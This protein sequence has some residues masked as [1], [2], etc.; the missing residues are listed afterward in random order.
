MNNNFR[1]PELMRKAGLSQKDLAEKA[2]LTPVGISKLLSENGNPSYD[3]LSKIA[4]ALDV[5]VSELF[6]PSSN[7]T[8][9][10]RDS[11]KLYSF[12]NKEDLRAYLGPEV[13]TED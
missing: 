1:I 10:V 12:D 2:G 6:A 3:T 11:G 5:P 13:N 8:A 9:L 7:F 4:E